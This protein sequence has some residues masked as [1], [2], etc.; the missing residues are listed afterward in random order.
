MAEGV[1]YAELDHLVRQKAQAPFQAAFRG[2]RAG[3]SDEL[4][5]FFPVKPALTFAVRTLALNR[6]LKTALTET[7]ADA[8]DSSGGKFESL[9][10]S[11]VGPRR[12]FRSL[13]GLQQNA[14][15]GLLPS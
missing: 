6:P 12:S 5:L 4:C 15:T 1:Y 14:G 13:V 11:T 3:K 10:D 2:L 8:G 9:G 7:L